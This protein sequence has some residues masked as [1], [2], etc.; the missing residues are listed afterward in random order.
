MDNWIT[1]VAHA[2]SADDV[3]ETTRGFVSVVSVPASSPLPRACRPPERLDSME[4]LR[5]YA[6]ALVS[7]HTRQAN[8]AA[9]YWIA[10]Y[11]A[12]AA[13]RLAEILQDTPF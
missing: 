9:V 4:E 3:L 6:A 11:F 1:R 8:T 12:T 10:A 7:F 13:V 5:R 2:R